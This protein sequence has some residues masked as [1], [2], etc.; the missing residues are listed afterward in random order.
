[1]TFAEIL[2][3]KG[4][5]DKDVEAVI[6]EMKQNKIFTAGEE[7]LDVRYG[8]LK[9]EFDSLKVQHGESTALIEQMKKDGADNAALQTQIKDYED[10]IAQLE[11]QLNE[12]RVDSALQLALRDAKGLDLDYLAFK[13]KEKGTLTLDESGKIKGL[14]DTIAALKT[15]FPNQFAKQGKPEVRE[16]LLP[17]SNEGRSSEPETLAGA[18]QQHYEKHE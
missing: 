12:A 11:Q 7:N 9:T 13:V 17:A 5:S 18:I 16:N 15:Q 4:L 8:K 1:M 3:A 2:K 10:R 6:G 14:D